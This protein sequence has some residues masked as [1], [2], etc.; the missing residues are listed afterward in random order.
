MSEDLHK[1]TERLLKSLNYFILHIIAYFICNI[2][3]I[4]Y[5]FGDL[6]NRWWVF[7]LA[8]TWAIALIY[9]SVLVYGVDLL[10]PKNKKLKLLM[11]YL[12]A[13]TSA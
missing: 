11:S 1:N 3:M 13:L 8:I 2:A 12:T 6:G 7:L 9:H 4:S 5:A 10:K